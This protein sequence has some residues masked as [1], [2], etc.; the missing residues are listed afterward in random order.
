MDGSWA[1]R[2]RLVGAYLLRADVLIDDTARVRH[3]ARGAALPS[4]AAIIGSMEAMMLELYHNNVSV[5][6]QKVRKFWRK[7]T[8]PGRAII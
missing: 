1:S 3:A 6:A 7:R 4:V 2:L 8:C 5:C